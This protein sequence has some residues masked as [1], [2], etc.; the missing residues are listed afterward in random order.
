MK[1]GR[2]VPVRTAVGG[3]SCVLGLALSSLSVL[4]AEQTEASRKALESA[5][6]NGSPPAQ[7]ALGAAAES[8]RHFAEAGAWYRQG[9]EN[10][11]AAAHYKRGQFL[12][13]GE[14]VAT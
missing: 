11:Y 7:Y 9:A 14:G 6:A 12:K 3:L 1:P 8:D 10:G 2:Y 5:A 13:N 4:S